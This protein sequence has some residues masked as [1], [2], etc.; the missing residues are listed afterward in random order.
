MKCEL[1]RDVAR[2]KPLC[3]GCNYTIYGQNNNTLE[4]HLI[5]FWHTTH[6][7]VAH[8]NTM[9]ANAGRRVHDGSDPQLRLDG[10]V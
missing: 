6:S 4:I 3:V 2:F 8:A 9:D 5:H 1:V 10:G 7:C